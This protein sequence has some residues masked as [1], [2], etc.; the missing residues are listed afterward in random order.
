MKE[1]LLLNRTNH[2]KR[3]YFQIEPIIGM[4]FFTLSSLFEKSF[5]KTNRTRNVFFAWLSFVIATIPKKLRD[6]LDSTST[7]NPNCTPLHGK[8]VFRIDNFF[9]RTKILSMKANLAEKG[10]SEE[11]YLEMERKSPIKSEYYMGEIF[12]MAGAKR[13]HNLIVTNLLRELS[14]YLKSKPCEVY[15]SDMKVK[16]ARDSFYTYPDVTVVCGKPEFLDDKQEVLLNPQLIFEVLSESTEKYDRGGKFALYR[17]IPSI[18]EYILVSSDEMKIESFLRNGDTWSFRESKLNESFL[19]QT[20]D[21]SL[22]L[23][24]VYQKVNFTNKKLRDDY[25]VDVQ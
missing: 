15:P 19:I 14:I 12:A 8:K 4:I 10:F 6:S 20:L 1:N 25:N 13:N 18:Q 7:F 17:N 3:N 9:K 24:E 5:C 23:D 16:N 22:V 2:W 11:E 21:L